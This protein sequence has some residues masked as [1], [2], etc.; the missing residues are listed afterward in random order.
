[1]DKKNRPTK[2]KR[3]RTMDKKDQLWTCWDTRE[4]RVGQRGPWNKGEVEGHSWK[5]S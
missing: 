4:S 3:A 5:G 1:M 2:E